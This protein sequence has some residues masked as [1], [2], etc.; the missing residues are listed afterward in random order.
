WDFRTTLGRDVFWYV[1]Q[2]NSSGLMFKAS[3]KYWG[4]IIR[5]VEKITHGDRYPSTISCF[6]I[7]PVLVSA[8]VAR[9]AGRWEE[10]LLRMSADAVASGDTIRAER[11]AHSSADASEMMM[12]T[13]KAILY[14]HGGAY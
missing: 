9:S 2:T 13:G 7:P 3:S 6:Q 5:S 8:G 10:Q 11:I 14:F 12:G 1:G 4:P